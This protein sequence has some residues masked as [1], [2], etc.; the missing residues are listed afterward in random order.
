MRLCRELIS[1]KT[2]SENLR[3]S[4]YKEKQINANFSLE[5][6]HLESIYSDLLN[7]NKIL[8]SQMA[9]ET[10]SDLNKKLKNGLN[11]GQDLM[12]KMSKAYS[13]FQFV[14]QELEHL[15]GSRDFKS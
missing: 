13:C 1:E 8:K 11:Y 3:K 15:E 9:Q 5:M 4:L 14:Q 10:I 2:N 6:E 7:E 12:I